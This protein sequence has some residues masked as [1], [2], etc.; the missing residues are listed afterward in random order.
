MVRSVSRSS[1]RPGTGVPFSGR[2]QRPLPRGR[3]VSDLCPPLGISPPAERDHW[4][5][6]C[7]FEGRRQTSQVTK[8]T[9]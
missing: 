7:T 1:R 4:P 2:H 3:V 8:L 9:N 6:S 5:R